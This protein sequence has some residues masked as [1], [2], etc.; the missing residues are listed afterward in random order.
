MVD[1][2]T[3][4]CDIEADVSYVQSY[5]LDSTHCCRKK[6]ANFLPTTFKCIFLMKCMFSDI[7]VSMMSVSKNN[8]SSLGKEVAS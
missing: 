1:W 6:V 8:K 7:Q 5:L 4:V 2:L 3:H